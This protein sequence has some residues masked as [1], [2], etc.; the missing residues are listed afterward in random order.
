M[1]VTLADGN[2]VEASETC[3]VSLVFC[4]DTGHAVSCMVGC[5]VFPPESGCSTG[6]QL[7]ASHKPSNQL[8]GLY[9]VCGVCRRY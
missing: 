3:I 8:V 6:L 1:S 2:N 4:S 7:V 9:S 5:H